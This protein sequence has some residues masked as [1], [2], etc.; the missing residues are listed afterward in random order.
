[1]VCLDKQYIQLQFLAAMHS[2]KSNTFVRIQVIPRVYKPQEEPEQSSI[3]RIPTH[4]LPS[5]YEV[6]RH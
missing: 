3:Q 5:A 1:M 2:R 4:I 6:Q